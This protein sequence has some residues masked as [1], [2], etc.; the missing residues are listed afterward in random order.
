MQGWA[1]CQSCCCSVSQI[2]VSARTSCAC[3][4]TTLAVTTACLQAWLRC[5]APYSHLS[6]CM[7]GQRAAR[8]DCQ[9]PYDQEQ[10]S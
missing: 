4:A 5:K 8:E 2:W 10:A 1:I 3:W 9:S 7:Q 6:R